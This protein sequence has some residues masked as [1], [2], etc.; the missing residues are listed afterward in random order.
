MDLSK[1]QNGS[2]IRGVALEGVPGEAV[3]LTPE[4][5]GRIALAFAR[6]LSEKTDR[7]ADALRIS[8]GRDPRLSGEALAGGI[9]AALLA[10]GVEV[11]DY[12]LAS[13]PAMFMSTLLDGMD[14]AIMITASHLPYNRN[15]MKFFSRGG[16]LEKGDIR[17]LLE[18][19][20]GISLSGVQGSGEMRKKD[21]LKEYAAY[22]TDYIRRQAADPEDPDHPL[23]GTRI[24][25]DAGNGS[26]GFFAGGVLEALGADTRGSLFLDPDGRFP[27][28]APNPEDGAALEAL[29]AAVRELGADLGIIFDTDVDRA[30]LIGRDGSP[31]NRNA[32]IA[33]V[34]AVV[35]EQYPGTWIVTDSITSEGLT[36]FIVRHGG[37]HHRFKRGYRNVINEAIRLNEAGKEC[38]LAI[39]T[40]GHAAMRENYWLDDGAYLVSFLLTKMARLRREG[41]HPEDL[42]ASLQP[43]RE[44]QELRIK[45][46]GEDFKTYGQQVLDDLQ[47]F[48]Q[49][50]EGWSLVEPNYEG[51]R[52]RCGT[53]HGDGWFLL[54]LS[55]HDP[56]LPLNAES[57]SPGGVRVMIKKL[58]SFLSRYDQLDRSKVEKYL[59]G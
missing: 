52:V 31:I 26:G 6:W 22:L 11:W 2:D 16:G 50:E 43:P 8:L 27:N 23:R 44:A 39:E 10:D 4:I 59:E 36:E 33:L 30:A 13:T 34:A 54:R 56:V 38:H 7:K 37:H 58:N 15:G 5:A 41:K 46:L 17:I 51:V 21:F 1:L 49:T 57:N 24:L 18:E 28:H 25:V 9:A 53:P 19:A 12:G 55:L 14:G 3:N 45:I 29:S 40:S 20:E 35:L 42:I 47:A 32:L 48:V